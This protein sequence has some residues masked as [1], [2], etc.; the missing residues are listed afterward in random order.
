MPR[1]SVCYLE[2]FVTYQ[3]EGQQADVFGA[4]LGSS[5]TSRRV[6]CALDPSPASASHCSA[7]LRRDGATLAEVVHMA[8]GS[9]V[10]LAI[11]S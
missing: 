5:R 4:H 3:K 8:R 11:R 6:V 10:R 1:R 7:R 2:C 9:N